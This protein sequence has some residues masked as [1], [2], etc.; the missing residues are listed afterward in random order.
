MSWRIERD[1]QGTETEVTRRPDSADDRPPAGGLRDRVVAGSALLMGAN[2]A[3]RLAGVAG[4]VVLARLLTPTDYGVMALALIAIAFADQ[5][6]NLNL[7]D[8]L[9]R[10]PVV[11]ERD[12]DTVFTLSLI[13]G[14]AAGAAIFASAG[15]IAGW[16]A[17]PALEDVLRWCAAAPLINALRNPRFIMFS[18]RMEFRP[19][20]VLVITAKLTMTVVSIVMAFALRDYWALVIGTLASAMAA[21]VLT[22]ILQPKL[23]GLGL[24][25]WQ[26]FF[27]FGG[28]LTAA[29]FIAHVNGKSDTVVIGAGLGTETLGQ[30]TMG[31]NIAGMATFQLA[32]PLSETIYPAL[33]AV[34][35]DPGRLRSA[36]YKAQGSVVGLLMPMGVG[37]ALVARE[38]ITVVAGAKWLQ[39]AEVIEYLGPIMAFGM[40]TVA[41]QG[42]ARITGDVRALFLRNLTQLVLKIPAILIGVWLAGITGLLIAR[43]GLGLYYTISMLVIASRAT[44]DSPFEPIRRAWRS[45]ASCGA[46]AAAVW[47][48][49]GV[50]PPFEPA[51]APALTRLC[52]IVATAAPVYALAHFALWR[53]SGSPESFETTAINAA[54]D[55]GGRLARR[56]GR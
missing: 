29:G 4:I 44:G 27:A 34:S 43:I 37:S 5:L 40:L 48:L 39:A 26:G 11:T 1:E 13:R 31:E 47:A 20:V 10:A 9:I 22:Y 28:W 17:E 14:V 49:N 45:L 7:G 19:R 41:V 21:T 55:W 25:G 15:L 8:A 6:T 46:M 24:T 53:L 42:I 30:F 56:L 52:A 2:L 3:A 54:R 35:H 32:Q 16:M 23:P 18:R 33:A 38:L 36:Y 50:L 12:F 51:F